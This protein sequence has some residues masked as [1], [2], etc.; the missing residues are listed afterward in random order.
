[1]NIAFV[2][3]W[4]FNTVLGGIEAVGARVAQSLTERGHHLCF[5]TIEEGYPSVEGIPNLLLPD[6]DHIHSMVN[7]RALLS[8]FREQEVECIVCHNAYRRRLAKLLSEVAAEM[9]VPLVFEIHTDP[10]YTYCKHPFPSF[11]RRAELSFRR[12]KAV[13][14]WRLLAQI[15][16]RIVFLSERYIDP[17][18][19]LTGLNDSDRLISIPNPNTFVPEEIP[20]MMEKEN[21]LLYVGRFEM[22]VKR[23]DL[24]LR[25]WALLQDRHP[26]W[27]L[28][29]LGGG[30][31]EEESRLQTLAS[32]LGLERVHFEGIQQPK[33]YLIKSKLLA[34]VSKF[35]GWPL[36]LSEGMQFGLVPVVMNSFAALPEILDE[37]R[38]GIMTP[39][40]DLVAYAE[41]LSD[42]M[43]NEGRRQQMADHASKYVTKYDLSHVTDRWESMLRECIKSGRHEWK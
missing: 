28:Y 32:S 4:T 10:S 7:R 11:V 40:D 3:W 34:L 15:A 13:R 20:S 36:V 27:T 37:G 14:Q 38:A 41:A 29:L 12:H 18:R 2:N 30:S 26:D 31:S 21:R 35:E 8:Y 23:V 5:A 6:K 9:S 25:I 17:F 24:L 22:A 33:P 39:P 1:M 19:T 16:D 43:V 42:L